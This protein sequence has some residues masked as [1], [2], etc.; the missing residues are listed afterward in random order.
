MF[1]SWQFWAVAGVITST[2]IAGAA[3]ALL[4]RLPGLPNCP[5]IFWPTASASLRLYCAQVAADKNTIEDLLL[6]IDLVDD[7]PEDHPLRFEI[8]QHLEVWATEILKLAEESFHAGD[9]QKAISTARKIPSRVS[10]ADLVNERIESWQSI[11]SEAE[12]IYREAEAELRKSNFRQAFVLATRL[13]SVGNRYWET[14][15][16]QKL[17]DAITSARRD[18]AKLDKAR[19]EARQGTADGFLEAIKLAKE[20]P[21]SSYVYTE[22]QKAVGEFIDQMYNLA[23]DSLDRG[24]SSEALAIARKIPAENDAIETKVQDFITLAQAVSR[25]GQGQQADLESAIQQARQ[26]Q[27]DSSIYSKAQQL[28]SRWE[29]EVQDVI[30]LNW[31]RQLAAPGTLGDLSAAISEAQLVPRTNPRWDEAQSLIGDWTRQIQIQ[32]DRPILTRAESLAIPGDIASL[33]EAIAEAS[34]IQ[35]GRPLYDEAR[36]RLRDWTNRVQRV[37]DQPILSEARSLASTGNLAAAIATAERIGSDRVLHDEAQADVRRWRNQVQGQQ[38]MQDAY[39]AANLN[40]PGGL[41]D[42]IRIADQ[43]PDETN[44]R[45][46][47][48]RMRDS[49]SQQ[50]LRF[51][52]SQ[53]T[54]NLPEAIAIAQR[55]PSGTAAYDAA[56]LRIRDWRSRLAPPPPEPS[57]TGIPTEPSPPPSRL[58]IGAE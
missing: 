34:K 22:A 51:A 30:R 2:S 56:Q 13:L 32:E 54:Y 53:S 52:E 35:E 28:I 43:V 15:Q 4:F 29:L 12:S 20:I 24:Y 25:A 58:D 33:R 19:A 37:E 57:P 3:A 26:L 23:M 55:I 18:G 11:W 9:L 39:R 10:A 38:Y 5:S 6:A 21:S 8:D 16:H 1:R 41:A 27:P 17:T 36:R 40:T 49:W 42:A 44:S 45:V 14:T 47:A 50:L 7:L 31:A 48:N 46:E